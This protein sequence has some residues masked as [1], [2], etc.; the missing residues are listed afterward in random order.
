MPFTGSGY[1]FRTL[2]LPSS[3]DNCKRSKFPKG[4][5]TVD[6]GHLPYPKPAVILL[7][8]VAGG[9]FAGNSVLASL[10]AVVPLAAWPFSN[11]ARQMCATE[12]RDRIANFHR[13]S[14]FEFF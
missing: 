8:L 13:G 11:L 1:A 6:K 2:F 5:P 12:L 3:G 9:T 10:A 14:G 4:P 7:S